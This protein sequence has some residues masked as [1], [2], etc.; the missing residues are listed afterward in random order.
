MAEVRTNTMY[1]CTLVLSNV[2]K[3]T[4][5]TLQ[6]KGITFFELNDPDWLSRERNALPYTTTI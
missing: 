1:L 5:L 6:L 2:D 4:E 3:K